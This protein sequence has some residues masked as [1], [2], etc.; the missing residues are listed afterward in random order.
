M[1]SVGFNPACGPGIGLDH[2]SLEG[3][4]ARPALTHP[5]K[6]Q[7]H[8]HYGGVVGGGGGGW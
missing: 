8:M 2:Q 3:E 6:D 7:Q 5:T 4:G 1:L